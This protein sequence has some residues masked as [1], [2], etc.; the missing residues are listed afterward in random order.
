MEACVVV[1]A[2]AGTG[3]KLVELVTQALTMGGTGELRTAATGEGDGDGDS[4]ES[5]T[6]SSAS[7]IVALMRH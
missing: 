2:N 4:T 5:A 7:W 6:S 3:G 1:V